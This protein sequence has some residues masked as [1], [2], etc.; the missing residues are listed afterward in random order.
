[1]VENEKWKIE[2]EL[3]LVNIPKQGFMMIQNSAAKK[4][5]L[6]GNI[7]D[8]FWGWEFGVILM[9]EIDRVEQDALDGQSFSPNGPIRGENESLKGLIHTYMY[10]L[11]Y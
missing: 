4:K 7:F 9:A 1:M 8:F 11:L 5:Q 10:V 3:S 6:S 2:K